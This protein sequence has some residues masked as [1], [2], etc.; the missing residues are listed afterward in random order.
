MD[1]LIRRSDAIRAITSEPVDVHYP[2][3][4]VH[5]IN[6]IPSVDVNCEAFTQLTSLLYGKQC[7]FEQGDGIIYSRISGKYLNGIGNA[8]REFAEW[9]NE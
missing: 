2:S 8:M 7:Y 4:F 3:W 5:K 6:E 9:Y 1:D